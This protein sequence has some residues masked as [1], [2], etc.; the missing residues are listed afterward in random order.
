MST[1]KAIFEFHPVTDFFIDRLQKGYPCRHSHM[2]GFV[3][4]HNILMEVLWSLAAA[5]SGSSTDEGAA[6][7]P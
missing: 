7:S 2:Q 6:R 5:V 4:P 3:R 1:G